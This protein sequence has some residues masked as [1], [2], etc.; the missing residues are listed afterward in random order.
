[1]KLLRD[2]VDHF[3]LD[4]ANQILFVRS[5]TAKSF[6]TVV[7]Y[8]PLQTMNADG[9]PEQFDWTDLEP[10]QER[11]PSSKNVNANTNESRKLSL[12]Q[13]R[14][15]GMD[16][17]NMIER[18]LVKN[19]ID[20]HS[21]LPVAILADMFRTELKII[22]GAELRVPVNEVTKEILNCPRS[23]WR[24]DTIKEKITHQ[25][26]QVYGLTEPPS[27]FTS[28]IKKVLATVQAGM[29]SGVGQVGQQVAAA[30]VDYM[31]REE[32]T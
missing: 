15:Y 22:D 27:A 2:V 9:S 18:K 14:A 29:L 3:Q 31:A 24:L 4:I 12:G 32:A 11:L 28:G 20:K 1:M 19:A 26:I 6:T 23:R 30:G 13:G 7:N 5:S 16:F 25:L 8:M 10:A 17:F 21:Q